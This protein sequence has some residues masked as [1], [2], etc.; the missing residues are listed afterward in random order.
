MKFPEAIGAQLFNANGWA[1]ISLI[2]CH[3]LVRYDLV[4][5]TGLHVQAVTLNWCSVST[6]T[7]N[8]LKQGAYKAAYKTKGDMFQSLATFSA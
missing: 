5:G 2:Q 6:S 8:V 3:H 7:T 4:Q 1:N